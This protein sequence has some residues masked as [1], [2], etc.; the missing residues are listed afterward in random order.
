VVIVLVLQ[1]PLGSIF[2]TQTV[3]VALST[4]VVASLFQPVRRRVHR[5]VDRRFDRARVDTDRTAAAFSDRLREQVDIDA[6]VGDL[7]ATASGAVRPRGAT[8]W[9]REGVRPS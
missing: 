1:G 3:T 7:A 6:V 8:V 2:G 5:A 4:L 9:L